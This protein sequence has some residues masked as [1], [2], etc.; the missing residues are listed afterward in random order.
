MTLTDRPVCAMR[1]ET[2]ESHSVSHRKTCQ[3]D[4]E[5]AAKDW[6]QKHGIDQGSV[7]DSLMLLLN[8]CDDAKIAEMLR[9]ILIAT[10]PRGDE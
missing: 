2:T 5:M 8:A 4:Y 1:L 10:E 6:L 9:R 3:E 7:S